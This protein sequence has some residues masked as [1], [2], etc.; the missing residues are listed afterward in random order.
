[1]K[2]SFRCPHCRRE[3]EFEDLSQEE[4]PCP[5]CSQPIRLRITERMRREHQ[6]DGCAMCGCPKVYVQKDFNRTL[7]VGIFAAG[8]L[9]FLLCAW[10][11][12]LVE[13]TL[14]W[15]AFVVADGLLYKFL[16]DVT[17]C[18]RCHAQYREVAPNPDN[19]AFELGLA[20]KY[21]PLDKRAGADNP[22]AEWKGR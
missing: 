5:A 18:Y 7:G 20:E 16:P 8:A 9:L 13:G 21:D 22:A 6:V 19:Q 17:I 11:N 12:R 10:K 2:I 3:L 1:M 14:V 4:S 15:A